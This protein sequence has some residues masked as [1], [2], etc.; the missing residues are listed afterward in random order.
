VSFVLSEGG[1]PRT[2]TL[3]VAEARGIAKGVLAQVL[4]P[5][6]RPVAYLSKRLDPVAAGRPICLRAFTATAIL[7]KEANKLTLGQEL[8]LVAPHAVEALLKASPD[9]WMT[10]ACII[11]YQAVLIDQNRVKF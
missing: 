10:N 3:Y 1:Q 2:L 6:K 8:P 7:V 5:R 11:Q 9:R 4:G